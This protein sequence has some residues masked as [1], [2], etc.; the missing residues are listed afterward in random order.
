VSGAWFTKRFRK[1]PAKLVGRR[2]LKPVRRLRRQAVRRLAARAFPN[3]RA[4]AARRLE[5]AKHETR[6]ARR[7]RNALRKQ[8]D[9]LP[10]YEFG[11]YSP[12]V[13]SWGQRWQERPGHRVLLYARVDYAGSFF[14]W[15]AAIN[16]YTEYAARL[17]VFARH[18]YGYPLDLVFLPNA[19]QD[20]SAPDPGLDELIEQADIVHLK[21]ETGFYLESNGLPPD[22]FSRFGKPMVFTHYGGYA[23]KHMDDPGYRDFVLGFDARVAMTPDLCFEWFDGTYVPHSVD[24]RQFA[25]SWRDGPL[26]GHSPSTRERKGTEDLLAAIDGLDVE[27]ELIQGVPHDECLERKALCN[28]FFDQAGRERPELGTDRPIGWYGNSALESAVHGIPTIAHLSEEAFD[29]AARGGRD[30]RGRCPI[31]NTPLGVK[32]I[33]S[34]ISEYFEL[35]AGERR[36]LSL[37]TRQWIEDF[38]SSQVVAAQL[39]EIYDLARARVDRNARSEH[40]PSADPAGL[41]AG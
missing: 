1:P 38:H 13:E 18:R 10:R 20:E 19:D 22:L 2:L 40:T 4:K 9:S 8:L 30:I 3:E 39:A 14:K 26:L 37:R 41:T 7:E 17:I 31:I 23:R 28:L 36:E 12:G 32:G 34:T 24:T 25:Y 35:P 16:A 15:S 6:Q 21:D 5:A 33:R 29:G 11:S 27:L